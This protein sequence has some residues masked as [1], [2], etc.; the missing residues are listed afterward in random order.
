LAT[1]HYA[2]CIS[3]SLSLSFL[4]APILEHRA[5]VKRFVSLQFLNLRQSV[6]LLG[7]EISPTQGHYLHKHRINA[8]IHAL[9]GIQTHDPSVRASEDSS[10]LRPRGPC[11]RLS[12]HYSPVIVENLIPSR[13]H[14][15]TKHCRSFHGYV[16]QYSYVFHNHSA[17][18]YIGIAEPELN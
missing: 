16:K 3:S 9:S 12:F 15:K 13:S 1:C 10:C 14:K 18:P 11:D 17:V 2:L 5:S 6:G 7:R 8:N 4:V